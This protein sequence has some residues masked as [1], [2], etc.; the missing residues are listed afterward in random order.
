M[1]EK[2]ANGQALWEGLKSLLRGL[3]KVLAVLL[4][5]VFRLVGVIGEKCGELFEKLANK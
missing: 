3:A 5:W 1:K 2:S 4:S